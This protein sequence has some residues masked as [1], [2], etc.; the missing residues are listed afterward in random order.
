MTCDVIRDLLPL[1]ADDVASEETRS[2]VKAHIRTCADCRALYESMC[3]PLESTPTE[4]E[5]DYMAAVKKENRRF[6]RKL[7][8]IVLLIVVIL[9]VG[10]ALRYN[11]WVYSSEPVD[12]TTVERKL[13]QTLLT[14]DEKALAKEIF[15]LPQ[16]QQAFAELPDSQTC[17]FD[18]D[19]RNEL[20]LRAGK[21]PVQAEALFSGII[22]RTVW[23][24]YKEDGYLYIL[25]YMDIDQSGYTDSLRKTVAREKKKHRAVYAAEINAAMID[26]T[27]G[28]DADTDAL[29]EDYYTT[30]TRTWGQ[31]E[32]LAFLKNN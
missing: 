31:R 20:L 23:L 4:K 25:E 9:F 18:A 19:L 6:L 13:P 10:R 27:S 24:Q 8:G 3:K 16:V 2:L 32:W 12:R 17:D 5:M 22:G 1:C 30:Y 29:H 28:E 21:D 26:I 14:E 11:S 15:S 7:Y